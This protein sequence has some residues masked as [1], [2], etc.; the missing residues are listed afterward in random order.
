MLPMMTSQFSI[1]GHSQLATRNHN[2]SPLDTVRADGEMNTIMMEKSRTRRKASSVSQS[3]KYFIINM[4]QSAELRK[5]YACELL[6]DVLRDAFEI[7]RYFTFFSKCICVWSPNI[8]EYGNAHTLHEWFVNTTDLNKARGSIVSTIIGR[9]A[10]KLYRKLVGHFSAEHLAY[11]ERLAGKINGKRNPKEGR[12]FGMRWSWGPDFHR[13]HSII[14][15][16]NAEIRISHPGDIIQIA[17]SVY[18]PN[19][20]IDEF[21]RLESEPTGTVEENMSHPSGQSAISNRNSQSATDS[22]SANSQCS[23]QLSPGEI[24]PVNHSSLS[25][26]YNGSFVQSSSDHT[27]FNSG[28]SIVSNSDL[29]LSPDTFPPGVNSELS[30]FSS[31]SS[32][33]VDFVSPNGSGPSPDAYAKSTHLPTQSSGVIPPPPPPPQL[34]PTML[35]FISSQSSTHTNTFDCVQLPTSS[36]PLDQM[37]KSISSASL[38]QKPTKIPESNFQQASR[39]IPSPPPP[40]L[41]PTLVSF[42]SSQSNMHTSQ[43]DCIQLPRSPEPVHQTVKSISSAS[44]IQKPTKIPESNIQ[45]CPQGDII[46]NQG[47]PNGSNSQKNSSSNSQQCDQVNNLPKEL[48]GPR[49][50]CFDIV[51]KSGDEVQMNV[52]CCTGFSPELKLTKY[53]SDANIYEIKGELCPPSVDD[54]FLGSKVLQD[55]LGYEFDLQYVSFASESVPITVP[56]HLNLTLSDRTVRVL[57]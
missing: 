43:F 33:A 5:Y 19:Y 22:I 32:H 28:P 13:G 23:T 18:I 35:S 54:L 50:I 38:I 16:A 2:R 42:I 46:S 44:L 49:V 24:A 53:N 25:R 1:T 9:K 17:K 3:E 47:Q 57:E 45:Q 36:E 52:I 14:N 39:A 11:A 8:I 27:S 12:I 29:Q 56:L 41:S 21:R 31:V 40:P 55:A 6:R 51:T 26:S 15:S 34:S 10:L 30:L 48:C 20:L 4:L 7:D 37:V